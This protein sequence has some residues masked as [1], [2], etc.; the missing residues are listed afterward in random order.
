MSC[1]G[2]NTSQKGLNEAFEIAKTRA[3][4]FMLDNGVSVAVYRE[5]YEFKYMEASK[6]I[7]LG[8]TV[9]DIVSVYN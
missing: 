6:A 2:C 3:T 9:I 4:N 5:G 8:L 7:E 1:D